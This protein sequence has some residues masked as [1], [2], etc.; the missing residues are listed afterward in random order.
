MSATAT[1]VVAGLGR[2]GSSLM[3][4]MLHAGG[5]HC[6]GEAPAFED[7]RVRD[8]VAPADIEAWRGQAVKVLDPHRTGLPGD[9]RV[10][11]LDRD[12]K[13]QADSQA[14][15][16]RILGGITID[17]SKRRAAAAGLAVERS[18]AMRVIG[19]RPVLTIRFETLLADPQFT[20]EKVASFLTPIPLDVGQ[21][22][23]QVLPR[24]P[25]C[26][27]DLGIEMMLVERGLR[28]ATAGAR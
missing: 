8:R 20:A 28:A 12:P 22:V 25:A 1:V 9:V 2:C 11:W 24:D 23:A 27:P 19:G 26:R 13:Q 21:M 3:M 5:M 14:K 10:I 15:F 6:V 18:A 4:Q 7:D 16:L 17:R